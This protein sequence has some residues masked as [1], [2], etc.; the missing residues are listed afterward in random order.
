[1]SDPSRLIA[2]LLDIERHVGELGWD[3]PARLFA[4]VGEPTL[5]IRMCA[6][7]SECFATAPGMP[8]RDCN[9]IRKIYFAAKTS[10]RICQRP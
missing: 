2:V 3:Q 9:L 10:F 8:W 4:L 1:M 7:W 5:N 6:L